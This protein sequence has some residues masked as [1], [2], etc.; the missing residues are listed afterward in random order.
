MVDPSW[1]RGTVRTFPS[2][3]MFYQRLPLGCTVEKAKRVTLRVDIPFIPVTSTEMI[4]QFWKI[5]ADA[6]LS[7]RLSRH[8]GSVSKTIKEIDTGLSSI[9]MSDDQEIKIYYYRENRKVPIKSSRK[10]APKR[11][12]T[13]RSYARGKMVNTDTLLLITSK[14]A[15]LPLSSFPGSATSSGMTPA[16]ILVNTATQHSKDIEPEQP[17]VNRIRSCLLEGVVLREMP[18]GV[19]FSGIFSYPLADVSSGD[20][21]KFMSEKNADG[22]VDSNGVLTDVCE[23]LIGEVV[24]I[25]AEG[26]NLPIAAVFAQT[27]MNEK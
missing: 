10:S 18:S 5:W 6:D 9:D 11:P 27:K 13:S 14:R 8:F 2:I 7:S 25:L 17:G 24:K 22:W 15:M 20:E 3:R 12:R 23:H 4:K 1:K 26:L 16:H 21:D 19:A